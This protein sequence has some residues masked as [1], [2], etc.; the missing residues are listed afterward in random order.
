[1]TST[2]KWSNHWLREAWKKSRINVVGLKTLS[3]SALSTMYRKDGIWILFFRMLNRKFKNSLKATETKSKNFI[4]I[5]LRNKTLIDFYSKIILKLFFF[6][7]PIKQIIRRNKYLKKNLREK[8]FSLLF[9]L[10]KK[11]MRLLKIHLVKKWH[12]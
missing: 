11:K 4:L 2:L 10:S 7:P 8:Y 3:M 9:C 12:N 1:M 5:F 6:L